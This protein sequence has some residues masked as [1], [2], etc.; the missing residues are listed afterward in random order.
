MIAQ[1]AI[2][3]VDAR[4]PDAIMTPF[5]YDENPW[6]GW[7]CPD[8]TTNRVNIP[9]DGDPATDEN[10]G[11]VIDWKATAANNF[12]K[13]ISRTTTTTTGLV[14]APKPLDQTRGLV[15]GA[16]RP[17]LLI[18]ETLAFHDRRTEDLK[19]PPGTTTGGDDTL[20]GTDKT[21]MLDKEGT[22]N[23][24]GRINL[25]QRMRPKGSL[26]V[27]VYNPNSPDGQ[28]PSELYRQVTGTGNPN[29]DGQWG[30]DL[31]RL[32]DVGINSSGKP[33]TVPSTT[34][35]PIKYSPVW[36]LVVVEED[37]NYR[38][39]DPYDSKYDVAGTNQVSSDTIHA[40]YDAHLHRVTTTTTG[41]VPQTIT[42]FSPINTAAPFQG[43]VGLPSSKVSVASKAYG[44]G[45][46]RP[47]RPARMDW[48]G[49]FDLDFLPIATNAPVSGHYAFEVAYPYIEREFYFT[50]NNSPRVTVEGESIVTVA[51]NDASKIPNDVPNP[52]PPY[53]ESFVAIQIGQQYRSSSADSR[54]CIPAGP[55][56]AIHRRCAKSNCRTNRSSSGPHLARPLRRDRVGGSLWD[57]G[58]CGSPEYL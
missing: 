37:P 1:W 45:V 32:S 6:D 16:E 39:M 5:E 2:N 27:E 49:L 30:V 17:E 58:T 23:P 31:Q 24:S 14:T 21:L 42:Y 36:R 53:S 29:V 10:Q 28:R 50:S 13:V 47:F 52:I 25:D 19:S 43:F 26:F 12:A 3:C 4:D 34:A 44:G 51:D 33:T 48:D 46:A 7:G 41:A 40:R 11:E 20:A 22:G 35:N 8:G 57:N 15:W 9:L 18:T 54:H 56:P 55:D 38:N